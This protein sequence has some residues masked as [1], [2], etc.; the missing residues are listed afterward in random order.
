MMTLDSR[1]ELLK[2]HE[3]YP[4][5]DL[6]IRLATSD[7]SAMTPLSG[8]FG[9]EGTR[10]IPDLLME[11]KKLG[12]NI[13]GISFHVGSGCRDPTSFRRALEQVKTLYDFGKS[14]GHSMQ[15]IDIG[16]GFP[17]GKL[18]ANFEDCAK[19]IRDSLRDYFSTK[20]VQVLAEPGRYFSAAPFTLC[21]NVIHSMEVPPEYDETRSSTESCMKYYLND[22]VFGSF[23][24]KFNLYLHSEGVP[25][26]PKPDRPN[27]RSTIFGPTCDTWDKIE[28]DRLI[29]KM[30]TNEWI[31]YIDMGAYS[32]ACASN[33]NGF[34]PPE[35]LFAISQEN[36]F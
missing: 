12:Q 21:A 28:E 8:K 13:A 26:N 22:G 15:I 32:C 35:H 2:I 20:N 31:Y 33:F 17:G 9:A 34:R 24:C 5:A 36:W 18:N 19:E 25:L 14:L 7:K 16:G 30:N 4:K 29:E 6:I 10:Q 1:E 23:A 11:A 27:L 3:I